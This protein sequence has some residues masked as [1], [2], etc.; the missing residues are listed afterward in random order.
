MSS[1]KPVTRRRFDVASAPDAAKIERRDPRFGELS[2]QFDQKR[3]DNAYSFLRDYRKD[4]M[5]MLKGQMK[6]TK[7]SKERE[8]M[9]KALERMESQEISRAKEE[10]R[11][12]IIRHHAKEEREKVANGK[13][14]YYLKEAEVKRI[15][16]EQQFNSMSKRKV[17]KAIEKKRKKIAGKEKKMLPRRQ[18]DDS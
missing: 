7:D 1:K 10:H 11:A 6:T 18:Q 16:L 5:N 8:K 12:E 17:N 13:K 14:P 4:E 2:G 15:Q 9:K 3:F